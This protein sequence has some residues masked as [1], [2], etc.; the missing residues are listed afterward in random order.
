MYRHW[1]QA[2]K[3]NP[4]EL[5]LTGQE[6][7]LYL[8]PKR[9]LSHGLILCLLQDALPSTFPQTGAGSTTRDSYS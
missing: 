1:D 4:C 3:K 9:F 7:R 5:K 2:Q 8:P 6:D